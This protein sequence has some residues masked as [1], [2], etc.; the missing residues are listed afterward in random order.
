MARRVDTLSGAKAD[1]A[2]HRTA[3]EDLLSVN[4]PSIL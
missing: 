2:T 1:R 3:F 4:M